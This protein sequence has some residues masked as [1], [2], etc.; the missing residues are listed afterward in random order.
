MQ[1]IHPETQA[2]SQ[3]KPDTASYRKKTVVFVSALFIIKIILAF[4]LE[5]GNDEAYYWLYSQ[6]LQWNY[7]DHPPMVALWIRLFTVNLALEQYAGFLRLG[8][9]VGCVLSSWFLFRALALLH[10]ERAGWFAVVMYNISLYSGITA[11]L[12]IMPDAPEMVFWTLALL[13]IVRIT[14]NDNSWTNWLLF[15]FVA[16]LCIMSKVHGAFLWIGVASY[17]LFQKSDWLKKPKLYAALLVTLIVISPIFFWNIEYGFATIRF[18]SARVDV[19]RFVFQWRYFLKELGSEIGFNNPVNFFIIVS[20]LVAIYRR[21]VRYQQALAIF[22]FVG[23]PLAFLLLFISM[24]KNVTLPHWSGP[25]YVSLIPLGAVWLANCSYRQFPKILRWGTGV[26][27]FGYLGYSFAVSFY[28]GTYGSH[29]ERDLG[30]GDITLDMY[31]WRKAADQFDSLY[32]D[33]VAKGT[34]PSNAAMVTTYWWGAHVEYYFARP[35]QL[36]MIGIGKPQYLHEYLWINNNR[37]ST[38]DL[39][40]VYFVV[41]VDER[42]SL[43]SAL[44]RSSELALTIDINRS[45]EPAHRFLVYRLR[46]L[47]EP[48]RLGAAAHKDPL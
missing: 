17:A 11:G 7:F 30:R 2:Y 1:L 12:Y 43:P 37:I 5:L 35:L 31:G 28:P 45:G 48:L 20:G 8:S 18:H 46:G 24:F 9:L 36:K 6:Y 38:A 15:G 40:N 29:N 16:G 42:Y 4:V 22:N 27:L 10:S 44:Y 25:A 39:N 33:D 41:A 3:S 19:N 32:K 34:M 21:R 23:L 14:K 13:I 26:F 47:K